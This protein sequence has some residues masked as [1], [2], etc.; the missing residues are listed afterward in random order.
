[1]NNNILKLEYEKFTE[2]VSCTKYISDVTDILSRKMEREFFPLFNGK[3][4]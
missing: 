2:L 4:K 3:K 1:M